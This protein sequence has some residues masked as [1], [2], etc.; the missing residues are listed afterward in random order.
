MYACRRFFCSSGSV[1]VQNYDPKRDGEAVREIALQNISRLVSLDLG[2]TT[3]NQSPNLFKYI[4]S[5]NVEKKVVRLNKK[6]IGFITYQVKNCWHG[7]Y[8]KIDQLAISKIHQ[9]RGYGNNPLKNVL[10][11]LEKN[12]VEFVYLEINTDDLLK[13]YQKHNFKVLKYGST[14]YDSDTEMALNLKKKSTLAVQCLDFVRIRKGPLSRVA[15]V[16]LVTMAFG[17]AFNKNENQR[18]I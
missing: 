18:K 17:E 12:K 15:F 6:T 16:V 4:E 1:T 10:E 8:A 7:T 11:N 9:N 13:F 2:N 14:K 5:P 3:K